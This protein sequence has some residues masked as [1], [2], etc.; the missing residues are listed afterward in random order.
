MLSQ[1]TLSGLNKASQRFENNLMIL[2][3]YLLYRL[4]LRKVESFCDKL[5]SLQYYLTLYHVLRDDDFLVPFVK[6]FSHHVESLLNVKVCLCHSIV[7][8]FHQYH[9]DIFSAMVQNLK[10]G[11]NYVIFRSFQVF[12]MF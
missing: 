5:F 8:A 9:W 12:L 11:Q 7:H 6:H 3:I 1:A 2:Y 10:L 4:T